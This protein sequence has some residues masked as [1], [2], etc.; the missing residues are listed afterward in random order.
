MVNITPEIGI[1]QCLRR[2][3][4]ARK[5]DNMQEAILAVSCSLNFVHRPEY[6]GMVLI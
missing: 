4:G 5:A 3:H 6:L 2:E 1:V